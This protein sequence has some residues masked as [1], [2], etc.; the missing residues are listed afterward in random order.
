MLIF[1]LK[2]LS[3]IYV[4]RDEENRKPLGFGGIKSHC[5]SQKV[6]IK[7]FVILITY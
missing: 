4:F 1:F 6:S 2:T 7:W 5:F 3:L